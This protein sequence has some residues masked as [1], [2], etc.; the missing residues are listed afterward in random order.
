MLFSP[1]DIYHSV[2]A[3]TLFLPRSS[4]VD[5]ERFCVSFLVPFGL[6]RRSTLL[7]L[8]MSFFYCFMQV[9]RVFRTPGVRIFC[10]G[11]SAT[12][13]VENCAREHPDRRVAAL[14]CTVP[15]PGLFWASFTNLFHLFGPKFL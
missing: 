3:L 2:C 13:H 12:F 14:Q 1:F 10:P 15:L 8:F 5:C 11:I 9:F 6:G 7:F 4:A